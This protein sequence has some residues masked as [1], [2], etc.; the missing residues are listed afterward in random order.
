MGAWY[1]YIVQCVDGSLYTGVAKNIAA[2]LAQ[3][4]AGTGAKYTRG[5]GPVVLVYQ[6]PAVDHGTALRK[7]HVL[8]QLSP[9]AKRA[10]IE[11]GSLQDA[12]VS[13]EPA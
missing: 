5:R 10:L 11:T 12:Q 7:E 3:H 13:F 2:R 4:N 6:E 1:V 9:A 8:K